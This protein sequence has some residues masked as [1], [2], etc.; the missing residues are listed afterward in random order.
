MKYYCHLCYKK[1]VNNDEPGLYIRNN[2]F[3]KHLNSK[4]H[5]YVINQMVNAGFKPE[6]INKLVYAVEE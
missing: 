1:K 4:A 5:L 2:D 6:D 3:Q